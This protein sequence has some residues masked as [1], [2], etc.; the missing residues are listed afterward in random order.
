[1]Y[2]ILR[3][4]HLENYGVFDDDPQPR[5]KA[6]GGDTYVLFYDNVRHSTDR[7][8]NNFTA[9]ECVK[10]SSGFCTY[11]IGKV[12]DVPN[13]NSYVYD[14]V[15]DEVDHPWFKFVYVTDVN[16]WE[17]Q[18]V[19]LDQEMWFSDDDGYAKRV[20]ADKIKELTHAR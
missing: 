19:E 1:M 2:Y 15:A 20:L 7:M 6:K 12:I 3:T 14:W 11:P 4:Q 10:W 17:I 9:E 18:S 13:H 8:L 16:K 5:W